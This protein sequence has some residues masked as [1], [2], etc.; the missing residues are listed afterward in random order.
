MIWRF[1]DHFRLLFQTKWAARSK[2]HT[3]SIIDVRVKGRTGCARDWHR[4]RCQWFL[5]SLRRLC[6]LINPSGPL[7][8]R[9]G[10]DR[11]R[12][13]RISTL[14]YNLRSERRT[15][16]IIAWCEAWQAAAK[17]ANPFHA[18]RNQSSRSVQSLFVCDDRFPSSGSPVSPCC[19]RKNWRPECGGWTTGPRCGQLF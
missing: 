10:R 4:L 9:S 6:A 3:T 12:N 16:L 7:V 11:T 13:L 8:D 19:L 1:E 18:G 5:R 17:I 14:L 2:E 15:Q